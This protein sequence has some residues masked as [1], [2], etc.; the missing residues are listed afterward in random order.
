MIGLHTGLMGRRRGAQVCRDGC[1][2]IRRADHDCQVQWRVYSKIR[3][4]P[5]L[6]FGGLPNGL[7]P[8]G[9][10]AQCSPFLGLSPDVW[11]DRFYVQG[12]L[13]AAI[14][15]CSAGRT[16]QDTREGRAAS[17][18]RR[19]GGPGHSRL[20]VSKFCGTWKTAPDL[21][22][23]MGAGPLRTALMARWRAR[24]FRG[25]FRT[26]CSKTRRGSAWGTLDAAGLENFFS[27]ADWSFIS[28][29]LP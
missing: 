27:Q 20:E 14:A 22:H 4:G 26:I 12:V 1:T 25:L 11:G 28:A 6:R 23:R 9:T 7:H 2:F 18:G 15:K 29:L 3:F 24:F 16:A 17:F 13:G 8:L 21:E 10:G 19:A 5:Q